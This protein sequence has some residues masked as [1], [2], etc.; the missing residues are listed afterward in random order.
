MK[1][2]IRVT[3]HHSQSAFIAA[4]VYVNTNSIDVVEQWSNALTNN[5]TGMLFWCSSAWSRVAGP[6]RT[7][8]LDFMEKNELARIC[9]V[10][11]GR[12]VRR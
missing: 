8:F 11:Y 2:L 7:I 6:D 4:S 1:S 5:Q 12:S 3:C 9:A 10:P